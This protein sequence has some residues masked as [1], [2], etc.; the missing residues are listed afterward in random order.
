MKILICTSYDGQV[1]LY[2]N[3]E[4]IMSFNEVSGNV[5]YGTKPH[6]AIYMSD[7]SVEKVT[8]S[9]KDIVAA[10]QKL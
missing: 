9:A 8:E 2:I 4:H 3:I 10:L 6:T 7:G 1:L 5:T